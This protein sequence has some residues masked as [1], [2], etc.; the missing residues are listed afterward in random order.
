MAYQ[1][2]LIPGDTSSLVGIGVGVTLDGT[3]LTTEQT[4]QVRTNLVGATS[5]GGVAL[6]TTSLEPQ[7][8]SPE[9]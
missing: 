3:S 5:L 8:T 2:V 7:L 6:S 4:V 1:S 9:I